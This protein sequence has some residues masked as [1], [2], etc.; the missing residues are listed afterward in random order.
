MGKQT[1]KDCAGRGWIAGPPYALEGSYKCPTCDDTGTITRT[2]P[3]RLA[4]GTWSDGIDRA[5]VIPSHEFSKAN[6]ERVYVHGTWDRDD[7]GRWK[8]VFDVW[9]GDTCIKTG[10]PFA[11]AIAYA[12]KLA[13]TTK[14]GDAS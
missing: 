11:E 6:P 8:S 9:H 2:G 4:D 1:C 7:F 3:Y 13:R 10:W 14:N 5:H 12:D